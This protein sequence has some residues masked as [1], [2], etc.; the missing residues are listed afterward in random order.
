[1]VS[2]ALSLESKSSICVK[3]KNYVPN[4]SKQT[5]RAA[6]LPNKN[7]S[8]SGIDKA[9]D[10]TDEWSNVINR[11]FFTASEPLLVFVYLC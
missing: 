5:Y 2:I 7:I 3:C 10:G 4:L 6:L 8:L 1:M 11:F 9:S